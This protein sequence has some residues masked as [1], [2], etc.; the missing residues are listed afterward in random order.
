MRKEAIQ[1]ILAMIVIAILPATL[2][3]LAIQ[4][5][6]TAGIFFVCSIIFMLVIAIIELWRTYDQ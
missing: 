2:L 1:L 6:D 4:D 5:R 3:I